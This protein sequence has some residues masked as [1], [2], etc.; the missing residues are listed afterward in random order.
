MFDRV[1]HRYDFLNRLLS[2]GIDRS[3][4]AKMSSLLPDGENLEVLDLAT[5]TADQILFLFHSSNRVRSGVGMDLAERMIEIGRR[6]VEKQGLSDRIRLEIGDAMDIPA[7]SNR[8]DVVTISF[9]IRNVI[10]VDQALGEMYRVLKPGGRLLVLEFS[11]PECPCIRSGYLFYLRHV[12]P[13]I[14]ALISG[15]PYAYRYLNETIETF[16]AGT[17]LCAYMERAGFIGATL[18]PVTFGIATVYKADKPHHI[19]H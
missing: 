6:K 17:D 4:R 9:G 12:L 8:F 5:G 13:R 7:G 1:A 2:M 16:P 10:D 19:T 14:G 3:W 18:H 15:D 11:L